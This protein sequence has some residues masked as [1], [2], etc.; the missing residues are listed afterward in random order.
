[1]SLSPNPD[2]EQLYNDHQ[3]ISIWNR[4]STKE[5]AKNRW[6]S[7]GKKKKD[8]QKNQAQSFGQKVWRVREFCFGTMPD[9]H[10]MVKHNEYLLFVC[11]IFRSLGMYTGISNPVLGLFTWVGIM[12]DTESLLWLWLILG[13]AVIVFVCKYVMGVDRELVHNG[14][15]AA[16]PILTWFFM[17]YFREDDRA[18]TIVKLFLLLIPMTMTVVIVFQGLCEV[19]VKKFGISP[20][21]MAAN[22]VL[23][24]YS[25]TQLFS[26]QFPGGG[27]DLVGMAREIGGRAGVS[28]DY[29]DAYNA[30]PN[31]LRDNEN[32]NP[33]MIGQM[34]LDV[35]NQA[36]TGV[37]AYIWSDNKFSCILYTVGLLITSANGPQAPLN[38]P[39]PPSHNREKCSHSS[40][41]G[42]SPHST[43][44]CTPSAPNPPLMR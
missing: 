36:A 21:L 3:E 41:T 16:S 23:V 13:V 43:A 42:R 7:P 28:V 6:R 20:C 37:S 32:V 39:V 15:Y 27:K 1:M 18:V 31:Q 29:L 30:S 11:A 17:V 2:A 8:D 40:R 14:L 24:C 19:F 4:R 34:F 44:P 10:L 33:Q 35:L 5:I 9:L 26:N 12:M 25:G 22:I 38:S